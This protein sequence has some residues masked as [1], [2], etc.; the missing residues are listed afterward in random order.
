MEDEDIQIT[1]L[2]E[3]N[4]LAAMEEI[5]QIFVRALIS[6]SATSSQIHAF[7]SAQH[8]QLL[9]VWRKVRTWSIVN[10]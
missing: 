2:E 9:Q 6:D 7:I 1:D 5:S 3:N 8:V 4:A 10:S